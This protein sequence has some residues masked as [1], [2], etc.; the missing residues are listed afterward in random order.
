MKKENFIGVQNIVVFR[1]IFA[2][3]EYTI[4]LLLPS[5]SENQFTDFQTSI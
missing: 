4:L 5:L 2:G 1:F 3:N